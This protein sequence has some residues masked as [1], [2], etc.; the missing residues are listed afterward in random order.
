MLLVVIGDWVIVAV[1]K[2]TRNRSG[3][4]LWST[5]AVCWINAG[6]DA[7]E[8]FCH[9]CGWRMY[10]EVVASFHHPQIPRMTRVWPRH[11]STA[12]PSFL[13]SC[14]RFAFQK[15]SL[16]KLEEMCRN[17]QNSKWPE[18][19]N[20]FPVK[21]SMKLE[22]FNGIWKPDDVR[23]FRNGHVRFRIVHFRDRFYPFRSPGSENHPRAPS[24]ILPSCVDCVDWFQ[25]WYWYWYTVIG[26]RVSAGGAGLILMKVIKE[27]GTKN[28]LILFSLLLIVRLHQ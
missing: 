16:K 17:I 7:I 15:F 25:Y 26:A 21:F 14:F 27:A 23:H 2:V 6:C 3:K 4:F 1:L 11:P 20:L 13:P 10:R 24:P 28:V 18:N 5:L 9:F 8:F 22:I 12:S 19:E